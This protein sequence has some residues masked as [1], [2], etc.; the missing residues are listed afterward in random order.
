M[1]CEGG[2][3]MSLRLSVCEGRARQ[4]WQVGVSVGVLSGRQAAP[5]GVRGG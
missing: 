3:V 1:V 2:A 5:R 4:T